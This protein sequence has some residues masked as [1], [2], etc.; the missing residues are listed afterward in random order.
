MAGERPVQVTEAPPNLRVE[1]AIMT[2]AQPWSVPPLGVR[3]CQLPTAPRAN[4]AR[5]PGASYKIPGAR[6]S[7]RP[8][9]PGGLGEGLL[10]SG[11]D[12]GQGLTV[13]RPQSEHDDRPQ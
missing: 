5:K 10:R 4:R 9:L 12:G 7:V 3:C 6:C 8:Y 2:Q 13:I 11:R 1:A